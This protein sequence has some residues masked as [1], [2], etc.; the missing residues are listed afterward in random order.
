MKITKG[1]EYLIA[2]VPQKTERQSLLS[3]TQKY[4]KELN[5]NTEKSNKKNKTSE[6]KKKTQKK[7]RKKQKNQPI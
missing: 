7:K 6:N 3:C 2:N 5:L 4:W 1:K